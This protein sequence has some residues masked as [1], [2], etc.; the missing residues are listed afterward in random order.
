VADTVTPRAPDSRGGFLSIGW[1]LAGVTVAVV[2][3]LAASMYVALRR[4][5]ETRLL[6]SKEAAAAMVTRLYVATEVAPLTFRDDKGVEDAVGML[7]GNEDIVHASAWALGEGGKLGERLG[8]LRRGPPVDPPPHVPAELVVRRTDA[9]VIVEAPVAD[10]TGK[11]VGA[12]QAAFSLAPERA[13]LAVTERRTFAISV[14]ISVLLTALLLLL[15]RRIIV[16]PIADLVRAARALERGEAPDVPRGANDEIGALATAFVSMSTAI[17]QREQ[18]IAERN[19]DMRAVLDNVEDGFLNVTADGVISKERSRIIDD[20][21][22]APAPEASFFDYMETVAGAAFGDWLRVGWEFVIEGIMPVDVA[23]AQLPRAFDRGAR[24]Y[25]V[26]YRPIVTGATGTLTALLVVIRDTT[27]RAALERA[28]EEQRE[29]VA[30]FTHVI[31]GRSAFEE[32][33][34]D[35]TR[36]LDS[37]E[38]PSGSADGAALLRGLHTLKGNAATF[39]LETIARRCHL[40]ETRLAEENVPPTPVEL[41]AIRAEWERIMV[42]YRKFAFDKAVTFNVDDHRALL[43]LIESGAD[44]PTLSELVAS[45][46]HERASTRLRS[47]GDQ[48]VR[49]AARLGKGLVDIDI[50]TPPLRLPSR[51][52]DSFWSVFVHVVRNAVEHGID[53]P[54]AR[55]A[56]GKPE[57]ARIRMSFDDSGPSVVFRFEDDGPGVD[58]ERVASKAAARGLPAATPGDLEKALFADALTTRD[59]ATEMSGRGVGLAAVLECVT[60]DGGTISVDSTRSKGTAFVFRF[61]RAMLR[62]D[63]PTATG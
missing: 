18:R 26:K 15:A 14:G 46:R 6:G 41:T 5:E 33:A 60:R 27:E 45:W 55:L 49:L 25:S 21:F 63:V 22:G 31:E 48:I 50:A 28:Q 1:K 40:L 3:V 59:Q 24:S 12:V 34:A 38:R 16:R 36:L 52:W 61:P 53:A 58:W 11:L 19:D 51:R 20:W 54:D 17:K 30:V 43:K 8:E 47:I 57:R 4:Y 39:G 56:N 62:D 23:V 35:T 2:A 9:A 42:T 10:P 7:A 37:I 44:G 13:A 29:M 32:L